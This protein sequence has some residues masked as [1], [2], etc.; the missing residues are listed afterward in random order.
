MAACFALAVMIAVYAGFFG[1]L[2]VMRHKTFGSS[3]MDMGYTDQ[4]V[5]NTIHGRLF[6]FTTLQGARFDLPLDQFRRTDILLAFH[7]EPLL[8]PISLLYL[9]WSD[10]VAL[11]LL[12]VLGVALGAW[13]TFLLARRRLS[14]N[15]AG[16]AFA[17]AYLL[18]P[19]IQ[20]AIVADFHATALTASLFMLVLW[21]LESRRWVVYWVALVG[22][23]LAKED[24]AMIG[25]MLGVWLVWARRERL[26]GSVTVAVSALWLSFCVLVVLPH[27]NGL[28]GSPFMHRLAILGPTPRDSLRNA[29]HEPILLWRW[30]TQPVILRYLAGLLAIGG[31]LSL[32]DPLTL[33]VAAPAV[34]LNVFSTW[35][36][37]FSGGEHYS[38]DIVPFVI[39]SSIVGAERTVRWLAR[40]P[41]VNR[42]LIVRGICGFV[43]VLG[44]AQWWRNGIV[45]FGSR[46]QPLVDSEHARLGRAI[47]K[48]IP[49]QA[50]VSA[51]SNLYPH[52]SQREEAYWYPA[53]EDA[54]YVFLDVT[55]TSYPL[56]VV[57]LYRNAREL[58]RSEDYGLL[59]AEDGYLLLQRGTPPEVNVEL[60]DSFYSFTRGR[61]ADIAHPASVNFGH[62]LELV[63][64]NWRFLPSVGGDNRPLTLTLWWRPQRALPYDY[65]FP[66]FFTREDG[67]IVYVYNEGTAT[68]IWKS[69]HNWEPGEL[70]RMETPVL[71]VGGLKDVLVAV[72]RPGQDVW[73][74]GARL[75]ISFG[76]EANDILDGGTLYRAFSLPR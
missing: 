60:P 21:A 68:T 41:K 46:W 19:A 70:V 74:V 9:L 50:A 11:L 71:A 61:P 45:P 16:L 18:A 27:F 57:D 33:L 58:L 14:S 51:Q 40:A 59:V 66:L 39:A 34:A 26:V 76:A 47:V 25:G 63:G 8:V 64:W 29:L 32:L 75:P 10:P 65:Q 38:A 15:I 23:L 6:E 31:G 62:D 7:V 5:W 44:G 55:S 54:T 24:I 52:L 67:A 28:D 35:G 37:T 48:A 69:P 13:P 3:A 36:W 2:A 20:G 1:W 73:D 72:V 43:L 12:Q 56:T 17:A 4:V 22:C 30:V 49:P 42:L 53:T